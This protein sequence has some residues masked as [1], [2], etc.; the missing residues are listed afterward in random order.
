MTVHNS[1]DN[2][3]DRDNR[4]DCDTINEMELSAATQKSLLDVACDVI[5]RKLGAA[6][7]G[8][9]LPDD[10][11]L[12]QPAG[13]FVSVHRNDTHSLRGCIGL[14]ESG[15]PLAQTVLGAAEAVLG[16][17]RFVHQPITL[18]ELPVLNVEVTILGPLQQVAN[19]LQFE[20][21]EHGIHLTVG[22]RTGLFL[23]QVARETGWNRE[24]LLARLCTEKLGVP[25]WGWKHP[26]AVLRVFTAIVI[27]PQSIYPPRLRD[28]TSAPPRI[29]N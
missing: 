10:P 27:G 21:L 12:S 25:D 24:Q 9:A 22:E 6:P 18:P 13:C 26:T 15:K 19:P 23:P 14:M 28:G 5:R 7:L 20:P 3:I 16:D 29:G 1:V 2:L 8:A 11:S 4:G 17:P